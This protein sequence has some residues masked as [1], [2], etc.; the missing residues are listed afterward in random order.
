[1]EWVIIKYFIR[2][3]IRVTSNVNK[4]IGTSGFPAS[5]SC[6]FFIH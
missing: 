3:D 6:G 2:S 5:F 4:L 1:M